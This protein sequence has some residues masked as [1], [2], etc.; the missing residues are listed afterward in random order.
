MKVPVQG[1]RIL[2]LTTVVAAFGAC[3]RTDRAAENAAVPRPATGAVS[4]QPP[5]GPQEPPPSSDVLFTRPPAA[6]LGDLPPLP[7]NPYPAPRPP[8]VIRAVYTFAARHPEVLHY[9]P[10]FCGCQRSGHNNNDDCFIR[11]REKNGRPIWDPHG[12]T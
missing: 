10:C 4:A 12:M 1:L 5:S 2:L 8:D 6:Y 11:G 9:V 7:E 3:T